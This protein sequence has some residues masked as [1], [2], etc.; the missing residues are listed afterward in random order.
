MGTTLLRDF[1]LKW[2]KKKIMNESTREAMYFAS[3][4]NRLTR[5]KVVTATVQEEY[6]LDEVK[7]AMTERSPVSIYILPWS[8]KKPAIHITKTIMPSHEG[9]YM[10]YE[11]WC[12]KTPTHYSWEQFY[13]ELCYSG[14][15]NIRF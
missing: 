7:A 13:R 5:D 14:L 3:I 6:T 9:V 11:S 4:K 10:Y 15:S 12:D 8:H 1:I 2:T